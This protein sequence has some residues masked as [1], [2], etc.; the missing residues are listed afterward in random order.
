MLVTLLKYRVQNSKQPV[1]V[2]LVRSHRDRD[3]LYIM[4]GPRTSEG[5][6][7]SHTVSSR[8]W[9]KA[10]RDQSLAEQCRDDSL[11]RFHRPRS[12]T[13]VKH[14]PE[15]VFSVVRGHLLYRTD[16]GITVVKN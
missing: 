5:N 6:D 10:P 4:G 2:R 11:I 16:D 12:A 1:V 15:S 7:D 3:S 14:S 13:A 8:P 9:T